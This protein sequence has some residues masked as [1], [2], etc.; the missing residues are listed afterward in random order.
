MI[1]DCWLINIESG[2]GLVLSGNKPLPELNNFIQDGP[3]LGKYKS[4]YN[5]IYVKITKLFQ[6]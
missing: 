2:N 1:S 5:F 3:S 6:A 4:I